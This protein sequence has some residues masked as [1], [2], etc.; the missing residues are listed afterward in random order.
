MKIKQFISS[1]LAAVMV[2]SICSVS[3]FAATSED[4]QNYV[5][6]DDTYFIFY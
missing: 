1:I 2:L 3:A 4:T 6:K 5:T